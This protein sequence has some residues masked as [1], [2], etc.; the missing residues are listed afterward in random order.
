MAIVIF[1]TVRFYAKKDT[2]KTNFTS[3]PAAFWYTTVTM[4]ALE[5]KSS[6]GLCLGPQSEA[7]MTMRG[8]PNILES[9]GGPGGWENLEFD[10]SVDSSPPQCPSPTEEKPAPPVNP[11]CGYGAA[12]NWILL[13]LKHSFPCSDGPCVS[14]YR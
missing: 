14:L 1:A 5:M 7:H 3:I 11:K 9:C 13:N 12:C 4:T 2:N 8:M 10:P 6:L